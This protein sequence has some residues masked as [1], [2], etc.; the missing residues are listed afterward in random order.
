MPYSTDTCETLYPR[1]GV[2]AI[3]IV[4]MTV[5]TNIDTS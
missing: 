3:V 4:D 1:S 5:N 2:L